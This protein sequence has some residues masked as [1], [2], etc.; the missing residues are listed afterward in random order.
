MA[1]DVLVRLDDVRVTVEDRTAVRHRTT[2][3][4]NA[5]CTRRSG[6]GCSTSR[7][8]SL[9][10]VARSSL[11]S[12]PSHASS[13]SACAAIASVSA[14]RPKSARVTSTWRR[15]LAA[16][17]PRYVTTRLER[18]EGAGDACSAMRRTSGPAHQARGCRG[19]TGGWR[20]GSRPTSTHRGRCTRS[21]SR[22][23]RAV[24]RMRSNM[25][26]MRSTTSGSTTLS[27]R[28]FRRSS[29]LYSAVAIGLAGTGHHSETLIQF[30]F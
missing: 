16:G 2:F 20:S 25:T 5:Q 23:S 28:S 14:V 1:G 26:S 30:V 22:L 21:K 8:T 12:A 15:S 11:E 3:R 17:R 6:R 10:R 29:S 4:H 9:P 18:V 24:S 13:R 27:W 19:P 7:A